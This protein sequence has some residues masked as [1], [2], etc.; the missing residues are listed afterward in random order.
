MHAV[1]NALGRQVLT[2]PVIKAYEEQR[3]RVV[4]LHRQGLITRAILE[5]HPPPPEGMAE[6]DVWGEITGGRG[7]FPDHVDDMLA[8]AK[9][10]IG[11]EL[12]DEE[13]PN[14][15]PYRPRRAY[16]VTGELD[17]EGHALAVRNLVTIE[18]N[19]AAGGRH[20]QIRPFARETEGG[21]ILPNWPPGFVPAR[22]FKFVRADPARAISSLEGGI[23]SGFHE[24]AD[25][26]DEAYYNPDFDYVAKKGAL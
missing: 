11:L 20:V 7:L 22:V 26:P 5:G 16:L 2:K 15:Y 25:R 6:F 19:P 4:R 23:G 8:F 14:T 21:P 9:E 1:N 24:T 10:P 12:V 3:A 17:G 13:D 18:S